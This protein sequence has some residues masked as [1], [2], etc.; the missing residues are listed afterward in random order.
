MNRKLQYPGAFYPKELAEINDFFKSHLKENTRVKNLK[1]LIVPHAGWIYS[2]ITAAKGFS[3]TPI[4]NVDT[5]YLIGPSHRF[6]LIGVA[7][8][9]FHIYETPIGDFDIDGNKSK[10]LMK[11]SGVKIITEAHEHE[12]SLEV[13]LPFLK[14]VYPDANLVPMVAGASSTEVLSEILL[15]TLN[16]ENSL[17]IISSDLSHFLPYKIA[18]KKDLE[19]INKVILGETINSDDACGSDIINALV[20][21]QT[22][23]NIE[24]NLIDYTNSGDTAGDEDSVVGYCAMEIINNG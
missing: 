2:G 24:I 8:S 7:L 18:Q 9:N 1:G 5:I 3:H 16:E 6:P 10:E 19:S 17:T 22:Q 21:I 13:E 20:E 14:K 12:H 23:S 11:I 15:K 4:E